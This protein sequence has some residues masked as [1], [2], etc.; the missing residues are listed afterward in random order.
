MNALRTA[1]AGNPLAAG[2]LPSGR[3]PVIAV[4]MLAALLAFL[5]VFSL[6]LALAAGRLGS[7]WQRGLA[8]S[9]TL[10]II[11]PDGS[12]E[13]QARAALDV[14]RGTPGVRS[15][16]MLDVAEQERLLEPWLGP[17]VSIE[18]L[19]VPLMVEVTI[20]RAAL[21]QPA[22]VARLAAEAP[23]ALYDDHAGWRE[24]LVAAARHAVRFALACLGLLAL[25]M[26]VTVALG[27]RATLAASGPEVTMLRLVGA[28]D[29]LIGEALTRRLSLGILV[30][31][32]AGT[33]AAAAVVGLLPSGSEQ[34]FFLV[35]IG[36]RG[37]EWLL[38]PLVPAGAWLIAR[39][40][41]SLAAR[42]GLRAWS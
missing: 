23:G 3:H 26:A 38:A 21:D 31:A 28:R 36:L 35:G 17:D 8:D 37:W 5:A 2:L 39:A 12:I 30:G 19:P 14:L 27:T 9:A 40:S 1:I 20:D 34:G 18:S 7:D 6:A 16:R 41:A 32:S 24:P 42:R 29:Q 22:L 33:L 15:V 10:Q 25:G 11:A 4:G 13:E